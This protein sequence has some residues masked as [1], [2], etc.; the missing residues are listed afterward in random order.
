[1]ASDP[2]DPPIQPAR[3]ID[4]QLACLEPAQLDDTPDHRGFTPLYLACLRGDEEAARAHLQAGAKVQ[5]A[6]PRADK[7]GYYAPFYAACSEGH[8]DCA[9]LCLEYGARVDRVPAG[10]AK[11][12]LV[13]A[14]QGGHTE[15]A[16]LCLEAGANIHGTVSEEDVQQELLG[17]LDTPLL[18]AVRHGH[19]AVVK[20]LCLHQAHRPSRHSREI[21]HIAREIREL[22][23]HHNLLEGFDNILSWLQCT[24][25]F[26]TPLHYLE[27][28][29]VDQAEGLLRAGASLDARARPDAPSPFELACRPGLMEACGFTEGEASAARS[30]EAA[31]LVIAA[32]QPWSAEMHRLWPRSGRARAEELLRLGCQLANT[33]AF[34]H[35]PQ[36]MMDVWRSFVMPEA[37]VRADFENK[38][39]AAHASRPPVGMPTHDYDAGTAHVMV[40]PIPQPTLARQLSKFFPT[41]AVSPRALKS[42]LAAGA[43]FGMVAALYGSLRS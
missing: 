10:S 21:R 30:S 16:R 38:S 43:G 13:K 32:S 8:V 9:R 34:A 39:A 40:T 24:R 41:W 27:L 1:M 36:A 35:A 25:D 3:A 26:V 5:G 15:C 11:T 12:P 20:L 7:C 6:G 37:L 28:I 19:L 4:G 2:G 42:L 18:T 17:G 31:R 29:S 22:A 14:C 23:L 33:G